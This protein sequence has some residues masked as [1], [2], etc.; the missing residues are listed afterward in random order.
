[1]GRL[2]TPLRQELGDFDDEDL[3]IGLLV[4]IEA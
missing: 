4:P 3:E 2:W 1:V